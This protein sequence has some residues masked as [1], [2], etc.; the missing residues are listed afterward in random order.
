MIEVFSVG[1]AHHDDRIAAVVFIKAAGGHAD[2][3]ATHVHA[4]GVVVGGVS[5]VTEEVEFD[6][7][8]RGEE[9]GEKNVGSVGSTTRQ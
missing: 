6:L 4:V 1:S 8:D 9:L 7:V 2:W 3:R 5:H